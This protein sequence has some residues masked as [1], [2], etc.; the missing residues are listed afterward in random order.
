LN[1]PKPSFKFSDVRGF[2]RLDEEGLERLVERKLSESWLKESL[3][4]KLRK[5]KITFR[6]FS[7]KF[8]DVRGFGRL[9][10]E[11]FGKQVERELSESWLEEFLCRKL[12]KVIFY[13]FPAS[14]LST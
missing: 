12:R 13:I 11:G 1:I 10:E 9:D 2:G 6:S 3:C 8:S 4:R 7:F 14:F 5:D